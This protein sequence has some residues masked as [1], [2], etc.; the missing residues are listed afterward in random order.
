MAAAVSAYR[1]RH[2]NGSYLGESFHPIRY[3]SLDKADDLRVISIDFQVIY[4]GFLL[5][6]YWT[7]TD[8]EWKMMENDG[9]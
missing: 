7:L 1:E 8:F 9:K 6:F 3:E 5:D 4:I 2:G